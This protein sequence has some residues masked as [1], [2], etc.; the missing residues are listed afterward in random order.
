MS[1]G[2]ESGEFQPVGAPA[3]GDVSPHILWNP[4][5][6]TLKMLARTWSRTMLLQAWVCNYAF[7]FTP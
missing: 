6:S 5:I 1:A 7:V 3:D 4:A 2:D